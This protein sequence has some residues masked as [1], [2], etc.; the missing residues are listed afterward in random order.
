MNLLGGLINNAICGNGSAGTGSS[1]VL[2]TAQA[3]S[4]AQQA[5]ARENIGGE[6]AVQVIPV[7]GPEVAISPA[8]NCIYQCGELNSLSIT[9]PPATGAWSVEFTS[10]N[11]ATTTAIP[12]S[13]LGLEDFAAQENTVYEINVLN[14]RAFIGSWAVASGE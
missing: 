12:A 5:Q 11:T 8:D 7:A 4:P 14:S 6:A 2:Y 1:A 9:N 10:G 3:L 13:I